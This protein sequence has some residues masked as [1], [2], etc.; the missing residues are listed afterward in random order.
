MT[1]N[2]VEHRAA[3]AVNAPV[4]QVYN[5]FSHFNDFPKFMSFVKEV[6]Y[7]NDQQSHWVAEV[8]GKHEWDAVN[9]N[10]LPDK[11]IGWHS[12]SGLVNSGRVIFE[13]LA[14]DQTRVSV[15][16]N[17][18]PPAGIL[19]DI[20]EHLGVGRHF[21][22]VL[23]NDLNHFAK[24]VDL[25]PANTNDPNWSQYLFHPESAAVQGTTTARQNATMGGDFA[26]PEL[27][28]GVNSG[29]A[30]G[31]I[32]PETGTNAPLATNTDRPIVLDRDIIAEP[33]N[34]PTTN[35][36]PVQRPD[37]ADYPV[38]NGRLLPPDYNDYGN[39]V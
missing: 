30:I 5:L 23:Q 34:T 37:E 33:V 22:E 3:V 27:T 25:A 1:Q 4:H 15:F 26:A 13:P 35:G 2:M 32:P 28:Q 6:T 7:Y 39:K 10:W 29:Q 12:T 31:F 17:Y 18:D 19:G 8:S 24:M 38:E 16:I 9:E 20:G 21:D 36:Q 14:E 11:Q